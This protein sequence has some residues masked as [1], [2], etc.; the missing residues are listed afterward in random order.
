MAEH[1]EGPA[2]L[3]TVRAAD[4]ID[5]RKAL[6]DDFM[7]GTKWAV[8]VTVAILVLMWLFLV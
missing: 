4:I 5:E 7:Q 8:I 6:Y 2:E 1:A 3:V